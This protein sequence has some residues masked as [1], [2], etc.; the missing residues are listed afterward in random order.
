MDSFVKY[1][2]PLFLI[3]IFSG[4]SDDDD[5]TIDPSETT[6]TMQ[7]NATLNGEEFT[8][9]EEYFDFAN[10][11][12]V[13]ESLLFYVSNIKLIDLNNEEIDFKDVALIDF[14]KDETTIK[15]TAEPGN[16]IGI[17][18]GIG[19][20]EVLN[21]SDHSTF[22]DTHPLST[23]KNMYWSWTQKYKFIVIDGKTDVDGDDFLDP[24]SFHTGLDTLYKT[25]Q[26][27]HGFEVMQDKNKFL[28]IDFDVAD[29]FVGR[30]TVDVALENS[31]HGNTQTAYIAFRITDNL[32]SSLHID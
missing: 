1:F 28:R 16:Y 25:T 15:A 24:F 6:V 17:K 7:F 22:P 21:A 32:I 2:I 14:G 23:I 20:D 8:V 13:V 31:W 29:L 27:S 19:L 30:D 9:N 12:S 26:I 18:M 5:D 11:K 4:C 10:R 3:A